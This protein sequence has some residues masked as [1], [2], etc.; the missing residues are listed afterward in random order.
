MGGFWDPSTGPTGPTEPKEPTESPGQVVDA[1]AVTSSE[2]LLYEYDSII[3]REDSSTQAKV[4][5]RKDEIFDR[6]KGDGLGKL[7]L[8]I[9]TL[10]F[11]TQYLGRWIG[12]LPR[13]QLEVMT[14][15][16]AALAVVVYCLWWHK[17]LNVQFPIIVH[18][19]RPTVHPSPSIDDYPGVGLF[20]Y[21]RLPDPA[22]VRSR[23][24]MTT[25]MVAVIFGGIHCLAWN[26]PFPTSQQRLI[27]RICAT[28]ITAGPV[29]IAI[30]FNWGTD[31]VDIP[32]PREVWEEGVVGG[33]FAFLLTCYVI[34]RGILFVITLLALRY[35]PPGVYQTIPWASFIP[36]L[37]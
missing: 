7:I 28:F 5:I 13:T 34:G 33:V 31:W 27:W 1:R 14:L 18:R 19:S 29:L 22:E 21:G 35:S 6:S 8:V 24:I 32:N 37:G 16:Y 15:A 17:P 3:I 9:Q 23:V 11:V 25:A 4:A 12:H 26:F 30:I 36:H 20:K 2:N 10:W